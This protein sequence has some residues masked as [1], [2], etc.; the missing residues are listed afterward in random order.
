M[1]TTDRKSAV[2]QKTE[3]LCQAVVDQPSFQQLKESVD[4]FQEDPEAQMLYRSL[5]DKQD[6]LQNKQQ[7]GLQLTDEEVRDFEQERD[8]LFAHPVAKAF[9]DA[10]QQIQKVHDSITRYLNKTFELGRVPSEEEARAFGCCGGGGGGGCG[11][12]G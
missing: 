2:I 5:V 11:C 7:R 9:I 8:N 1:L 10:Q 12:Q 4:R 3:E 6:R